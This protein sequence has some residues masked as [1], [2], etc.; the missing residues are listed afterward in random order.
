[1]FRPF[2]LAAARAIARARTLLPCLL[3]YLLL[4]GAIV[5]VRVTVVLAAGDVAAPTLD[6]AVGAVTA[7]IA[8]PNS[9]AAWMGLVCLLCSGICAAT[10]TPKSDTPW[11]A[12]YQLIELL[13]LNKGFAKMVHPDEAS[14]A[15]PR[16]PAAAAV[17]LLGLLVGAG[18][19]SGCALKNPDG[20]PMTLAQKFAA[21]CDEYWAG[22]PQL[23]PLIARVIARQG[24]TAAKVFQGAKL[25][26]ADA[27][28]RKPDG[29]YVNAVDPA[30]LATLLPEL[31]AA[32]GQL[33]V[34]FIP[35][36]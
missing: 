6:Q 20:T 33:T 10:T 36:G 15:T 18:G 34:L 17:V 29:S 13:A 26:A 24:P 27:C 31:L 16:A 3:A 5:A 7:V 25:V 1:M 19:L 32:A 35:A 30:R 8:T 14:L 22:E 2:R 21:A 28:A 4:G 9:W 23:D 11:G 12:A